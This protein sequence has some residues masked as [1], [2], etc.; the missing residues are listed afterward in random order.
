MPRSARTYTTSA[1]AV[2]LGTAAAFAMAAC[3][4]SAGGQRSNDFVIAVAPDSVE[5]A[6]LGEIYR[7]L[8]ES[9]GHPAAVE[10]IDEAATDPAI[11]LVRSGQVDMAIACT[12][13]LLSQI[14]P[15]LA[16]EAA[17]D[18]AHDDAA[19]DFNG[20][21]ISE[22][23]YEYAV[24]SFPGDVR[25]V[26]PS[27]AQACAPEGE[28]PGE[29]PLPTNVIPVFNK[30]ELNRG[31][32]NRLNFVNRVLSTEDL[33][34]MIEE[35]E[36]GETVRN[37]VAEWMLQRTKITVDTQSEDEGDTGESDNVIEQPPM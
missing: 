36:R 19:G 10:V 37:V 26:D 11:D 25:T 34:A 23:I 13:T 12:G 6:I 21:T 8:L 1:V 7:V 31:Q 32:L 27:P 24:G 18:I 2:A 28:E 4:P 15:Q 14:N 20:D 16:E 30:S 33:N 5:Q 35:V 3:S 22:T 29:G 9:V 17:A